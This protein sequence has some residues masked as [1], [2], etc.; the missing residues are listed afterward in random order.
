MAHNYPASLNTNNN[1]YIP[2]VSHKLS[3]TGL[4]ST[5]TPTA[6]LSNIVGTYSVG[7]LSE[8]NRI[9]KITNFSKNMKLCTN[10]ENVKEI[11][12]VRNRVG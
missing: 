3:R 9:G 8:N 2:A 6:K 10:E 5:I 11:K 1:N 7:N 12:R 4:P